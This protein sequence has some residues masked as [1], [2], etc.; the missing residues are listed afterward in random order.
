MKCDWNGL[1]GILPQFL[2]R[3]VEKLGGQEA[4]E[5]RLRIGKMPMVKLSHGYKTLPG[6]VNEQ[7]L[8]FIVNTASRYSP[9]SAA[10]AARGYI[11]APGGHR[12]DLCGEAV[13]DNGQVRGIGN[14]TSLNIRV[15]RDV[16]GIADYIPV[17]G[18]ML[19]LG[20]PGCGKTTLLRDLI[21][22][23]ARNQP[24]AVVDEREEL[25]P[26]GFDRGNM[27]D[28]L[29]GC[30]KGV[31]IEMLLRSMGPAYI[32]VDE[33][34]SQADANALMDSIGCGVSLLATAHAASKEDL[35]KRKLYAA[36]LDNGVF[37]T[38]ILMSRDKSWRVERWD[39]G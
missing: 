24:V 30:G 1:L 38:L 3:Q 35:H 6:E 17:S 11:T 7:D 36:L 15:A 8:R 23:C 10:S 22:K 2:C 33:I 29:T 13:V 34:T 5:L 20:P 18:N 26:A 28:V 37:D 31:G 19:I 4:E 16:P 12:I 39:G 25:F 21:R 27:T 9:W 14:V 32:A